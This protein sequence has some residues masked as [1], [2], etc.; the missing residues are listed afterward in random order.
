[1][2][3]ADSAGLR[4]LVLLQSRAKAAGVDFSLVEPSDAVKRA[5]RST[6]LAALFNIRLDDPDNPC[7]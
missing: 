7:A 2:G 4:G 6:G 3:Y 1:V 5:F